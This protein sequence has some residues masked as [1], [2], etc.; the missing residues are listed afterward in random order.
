MLI[1]NICFCLQFEII[2]AS[3]WKKVPNLE[4]LDCRELIKLI[5]PTNFNLDFGIH[6]RI[7]KEKNRQ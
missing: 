5:I 1:I 6:D 4:E 3:V 7:K 2:F